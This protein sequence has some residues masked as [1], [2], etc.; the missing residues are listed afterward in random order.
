M[1]PKVSD[2]RGTDFCVFPPP[3]FQDPSFAEGTEMKLFEWIGSLMAVLC[4]AEV[5]H[6][7]RQVMEESAEA[8]RP[9]WR[10]LTGSSR[11]GDRL[12]NN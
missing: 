10:R 2:E 5:V 12:R 3:T 9:T 7:P 1:A 8:P 6:N 11:H 4:L